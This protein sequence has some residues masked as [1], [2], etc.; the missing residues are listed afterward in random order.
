MSLTL[1]LIY[2]S[3]PNSKQ[4]A[5]QG[6][7]HEIARLLQHNSTELPMFHRIALTNP[8]NHSSQNPGLL[9]ITLLVTV[10]AH[11]PQSNGVWYSQD[12]IWPYGTNNVYACT[13][14]R[15]GMDISPVCL[16]LHND[17]SQQSGPTGGA[18]NCNRFNTQL[19]ASVCT[20]QSILFTQFTV[21]G[22]HPEIYKYTNIYNT[23]NNTLH[24]QFTQYNHNYIV[25][26]LDILDVTI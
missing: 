7:I 19:P 21:I 8:S 2:Q 16:V 25:I 20:V 6:L 12:P 11:R 3:S 17:W 24:V 26:M 4:P 5:Y 10:T 15:L 13:H 22:K 1:A 23:F 9:S 14:S 18:N